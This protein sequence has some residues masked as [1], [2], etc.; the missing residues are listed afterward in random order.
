MPAL[1]PLLILLAFPI[2]EIATFIYVGQW[3]G[4]WKTIGLVILAA[5]VGVAILRYQGLGALKKINKDLRRAQP[6]TA[7]IVDGFMIV[8]ASFLLIIPGFLSDII[9]LLLIVPPIRH[10]IWRLWGKSINVQTYSSG[11][12]R[13][14]RSDDFVDLSPDD[15]ERQDDPPPSDPRLR[16]PD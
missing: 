9:G 1:V 4:V 13:G 10:V 3:I 6:P 5:I 7:G 16:K 14:R 11:F 2:L 8:I 12:R 15:F